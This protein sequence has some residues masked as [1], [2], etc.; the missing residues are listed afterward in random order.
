MRDFFDDYGPSFLGLQILRLYREI[1]QGGTKALATTS[2]KLPSRVAS[3]LV[4]LK[5]HGQ[6]SVSDLAMALGASHQLVSQRLVVLNRKTLID[7][8]SDLE[9]K[10]R[11]LA[12]PALRNPALSLD[13]SAR[14]GHHGEP[15]DGGRCLEAKLG[16]KRSRLDQKKRC[17]SGDESAWA[18]VGW[19]AENASRQPRHRLGTPL[20]WARRDG[21]EPS[22]AC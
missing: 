4:F 9:D 20:W 17:Q 3:L 15:G 7:K 8:V 16:A 10:R 11:S 21:V 6:S 18:A 2:S 12:N 1:D 19:H 22:C 14:L 5:H 13:L